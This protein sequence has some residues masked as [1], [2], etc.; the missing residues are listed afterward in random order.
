MYIES[1]STQMSL[2]YTRAAQTKENTNTGQTSSSTSEET[3]VAVTS[4]AA[5]VTGMTGINLSKEVIDQLISAAQET[6][7][8]NTNTNG[9]NGILS[10]Q[11]RHGLQGIARDASYAKKMSKAIGAGADLIRIDQSQMPKNGGDPAYAKAFYE[12]IGSL[13]SKA[14]E[15]NVKRTN[16]YDA[17][18]EQGIPPA[19]IYANLMEFN[20][21]LT[22]NYWDSMSIGF[23]KSTSTVETF[24]ASHDYLQGL[25]DK[26]NKATSSVKSTG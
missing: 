16:F 2:I 18:V 21:N 12:R 7:T 9:Y 14:S 8:S 11:E 6:N 1:N 22:Q 17:Q 24:Q 5:A 20:A 25:I 23:D 15:V 4:K 13:Q 26:S 19:Q 10:E 3:A